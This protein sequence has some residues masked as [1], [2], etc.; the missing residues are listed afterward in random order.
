MSEIL[1]APVGLQVKGGPQV[2]NAPEDVLLVRK[3]LRANGYNVAPTGGCDPGVLKA[4]S[5]AAARAKIEPAI[6]VIE[7]NSPLM[8]SL[9]PK[10]EQWLKK[11]G[12]AA[13][14]GG[15]KA[16]KTVQVLQVKIGSTTH[17]LTQGDYTKARNAVFDRLSRYVTTLIAN[18]KHNVKTVQ[19]YRD[20][21]NIRNGLMQALTHN[22]I[23]VTGKVTGSV[24]YPSDSLRDAATKAT[25]D[26]ARA[27]AAKDL[28][29][30]SV[31]L[32]A[33]E[34]ALNAY[35]ADIAQFLK[36]FTGA[37]GGIA[38]GLSVT[39]AAGFAVV[40]AMATP[41]IVAGGMSAGAAAVASATAVKTIETLA[42][43]LGRS[44]AGEQVTLL[45][46]GKELTVNG[47]IAAVTAGV[48]ELIPAKWTQACAKSLSAKI[49]ATSFGK[50][51]GANATKFAANFLVGAG[52]EVSK[53][54]FSEALNLFGKQIKSGKPASGQDLMDM[55]VN[56]AVSALTA[57]LMKNLSVANTKA[58]S[59]VRHDIEVKLLPERIN[60][61]GLKNV[62]SKKE[63]VAVLAEIDGKI[64][65]E[66]MKAA[67]SSFMSS[68]S[69]K[70]SP[71]QLAQIGAAG[72]LKD[73][74]LLRL[75]DREM[76]AAL[77]KA[78]AKN[79]GKK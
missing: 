24:K 60:K 45:S 53:S 26:L 2:R 30:L 62:L 38:T 78:Q 6:G 23:K 35:S 36:G 70:E 61:L 12:E 51:A 11:G 33:A 21:L 32:P 74:Q 7:P 64:Q 52:V 10:Y 73:A 49:A 20:A 76:D 63:A 79:K 16:E 27:F 31:A 55:Y 46:L 50:A 54:S 65:E 22:S 9:K 59:K 3:I 28:K 5:A 40:G 25:S 42:D 68:A 71:D 1:R 48:G 34:K 67:A 4:L 47:V 57:G 18:H 43:N 56:V 58:Y 17:T 72:A 41:I 77:K 29:A 75:I 15:K 13:E 39:S 69:G 8:K 14:G 66:V 19:E 44:T 37:A